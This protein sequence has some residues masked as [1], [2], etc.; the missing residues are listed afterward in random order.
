MPS[1]DATKLERRPAW[2]QHHWS[3]AVRR[4]RAPYGAGPFMIAHT[5]RSIMAL[6]VEAIHARSV[7]AAQERDERDRLQLQRMERA[8]V[9][10]RLAQP[11]A[12][13]RDDYETLRYA[14]GLARLHRF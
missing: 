13:P 11:A 2:L 14:I 7:A 12:L 1:D 8:L 10:A 6:S 4:H 5:I 3:P 9:R